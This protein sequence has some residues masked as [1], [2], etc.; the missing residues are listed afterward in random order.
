MYLKFED[1]I[2]QGCLETSPSM[3]AG[4]TIPPFSSSGQANNSKNNNNSI[5]LYHL[6]TC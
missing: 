5:T 3:V 2:L 1:A 4:Q 6:L